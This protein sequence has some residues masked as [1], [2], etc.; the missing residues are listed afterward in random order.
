MKHNEWYVEHRHVGRFHDYALARMSLGYVNRGVQPAANETGSLLAVMEGEV[1]NCEEERRV[2]KTAG[3]AFRTDS[4]A[5]LLLHGYEQE[6]TAFFRRLHGMFAA[7]IWDVQSRRLMLIND[8]F[9]MKPLYYSALSGR[10]LFA[11]EIKALLVDA[12]VSRRPHLRGLSQFFVY[13][14]MLG[15][16][17]LLDGVRL[18]PAASSL[19]YDAREGRMSL[20]RY[21]RYE[22]GPQCAD[23]AETDILEQIDDAFCRAVDR[24]TQGTSRL[25]LSLSGGLDARTILALVNREKP[26]S[27]VTLGVQGSLDHKCA[28]ALARLAGRPHLR[29]VL[30]TSFLECFEEHLT[31]MVHL[32]DG[33]YLSQCIVMPT[34]P[35]YRDLGIEVLLR[36]HAGELMHM[37]KAYAFSLDDAAL[38]SR[39]DAAIE[40]WLARRLRA[41]M[42]DDLAEPLFAPEF[43]KHIDDLAAQSLRDSLRAS[44]G[45]GPPVQRVWHLFVSERLRRETA[46]S[47]MKFG[48]QVETRLPYL[49]NDLVDLLLAAPPSMKLAEN[50]QAHILRRR[51][52]AFLNVVNAN[53]GAR[54]GAGRFAK[55]FAELKLKVFAKLGVP[56]Y[57]PYER[58]GLWLRRELRPLV[59]KTLL[60]P[61]CLERGIFNPNAV[62]NVVR[63]H[64]NKEANHT[65]LLMALLIF[66]TGQRE[67]ID[68]VAVSRGSSYVAPA[69]KI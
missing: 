15:E 5:E 68:G 22:P 41:H 2:L 8:R 56:G 69:T 48:S 25:G 60:D 67:F 57:Q 54:L 13:G 42:L 6:G 11:S 46:L 39:D 30:S 52:P 20:E 49:D 3:H 40:A 33:Q 55:R 53:N 32:T 51:M 18:L 50:I 19:T 38:Q 17:T 14:Q 1:Y 31:R 12:D 43:H 27:T 29:Y 64:L 21:W 26:L 23:A 9:G 45:V 24:R 16:D 47:M 63:R 44:Q 10:L 65:F 62:Q 28:A 61:R 36:G 7:A 4:H 58:L 34:L 35:I 37:D 59:E 66:E